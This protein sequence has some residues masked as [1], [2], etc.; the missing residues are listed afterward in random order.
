MNTSAT[1]DI[2]FMLLVFFLVT[3]SMD[4]VKG[5][6]RQMA[7]IDQDKEV[8]VRDVDKDFIIALHLLENGKITLNDVPA[9]ISDAMR[10][11][12]RHLIVEKGNRHIIELTV[13]R[14]A[15]YD[16][17]FRLQNQITRAYG[18]LRNAAAMK[19]YGR[20]Y[21]KCTEEQQDFIAKAYPKRI[22]EVV[23]AVT[24][25]QD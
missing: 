19:R 1:A 12:L 3:T 23:Q 14:N 10:K 8:I 24:P 13:D 22:Q 6:G 7:P 11:E 4:N 21:A 18:E 16:S 9:S 15:N 25:K 17:Y 20:P 2:S 5:L